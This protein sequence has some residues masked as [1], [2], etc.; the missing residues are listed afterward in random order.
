MIHIRAHPKGGGGPTDENL[1]PFTEPFLILEIPVK[2][3]REPSWE[4]WE[5]ARVVRLWDAIKEEN[6]HQQL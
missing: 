3:Q 4:Y 1:V 6:L 5:Q 2:P